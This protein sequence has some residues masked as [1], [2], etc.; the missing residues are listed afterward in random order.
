MSY[1][2]IDHANFSGEEEGKCLFSHIIC[3]KKVKTCD[4]RF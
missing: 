4:I 3:P 1:R 2:K